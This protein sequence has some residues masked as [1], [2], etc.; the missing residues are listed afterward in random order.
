MHRNK[1]R[2]SSPS[3]H[4]VKAERLNDSSCDAGDDDNEYLPLDS[5][6]VNEDHGNGDTD[7]SLNEQRRHRRKKISHSNS[8]GE[9]DILLISSINKIIYT[10][11]SLC[12]NI[13]YRSQ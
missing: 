10:K 6:D 4:Y 12:G 5:N 11:R 13:L 8:G 7:H 2:D 3:H 9:L 1:S